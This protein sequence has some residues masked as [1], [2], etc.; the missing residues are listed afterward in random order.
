MKCIITFVSLST[1]AFYNMIGLPCFTIKNLHH[2]L[3]K[4]CFFSAYI[5]VIYVYIV[6]FYYLYDFKKADTLTQIVIVQLKILPD[7]AVRSLH[8]H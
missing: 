6:L 2:A 4:K 5:Y 8:L 7:L 1:R 3:Q